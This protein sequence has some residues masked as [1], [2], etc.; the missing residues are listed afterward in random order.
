MPEIERY[1]LML[2][3]ALLAL[4][5]IFLFARKIGSGQNKIKF[6]GAE[7]ELSAPSLVI[8]VLGCL[9]IVFPYMLAQKDGNGDKVNKGEVSISSSEEPLLGA[10]PVTE[11]PEKP[12]VAA[13][14]DEL[15]QKLSEMDKKLDAQQASLQSS[16]N[17]SAPV[18][19]PV[20]ISGEWVSGTG[21]G[22]VFQQAGNRVTFREVNMISGIT[23]AGEGT[24]SGRNVNLVYT[25]F[26]GTTGS[27]QL[28][29]NQDADQ[30]SGS[31]TDNVSRM[32]QPIFLSR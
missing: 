32:T 26:V 2:F 20:N 10:P 11:T 28:Q 16:K 5:G 8:F 17:K 18:A 22:Y 31:F 6:L 1:F 7:F 27:A 23:A 14:Q 9:L 3:G 21:D 13:N 4:V 15:L 24:I 30:M 19:K 12:E 25:T 29:V